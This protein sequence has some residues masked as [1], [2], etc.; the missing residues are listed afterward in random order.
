MRNAADEYGPVKVRFNAIRPGFIATEIMDN[1]PRDSDL[2][3]GWVANTPMGDV[4]QPDDVG[5][6]VRYLIGPDSRW[7]TGTMIN[8]DGGNALRSGPDFG[9]FVMPMYGADAVLGKTAPGRN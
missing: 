9:P 3:R 6:L 5:G 4:G 8:I 1:I 2:Y 7:V